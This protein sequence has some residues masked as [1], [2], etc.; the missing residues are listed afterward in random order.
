MSRAA[1][2]SCDNCERFTSM[3]NTLCVGTPP[4][5]QIDPLGQA[6]MQAIESS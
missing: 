2:K 6:K 5:D 1:T 3:N 4:R